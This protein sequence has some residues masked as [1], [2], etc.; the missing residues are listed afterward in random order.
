MSKNIEFVYFVYFQDIKLNLM[1]NRATRLRGRSTSDA[2]NDSY[3]S[4]GK[5]CSPEL[6]QYAARLCKLCKVDITDDEDQLYRRYIRL[7][8]VLWNSTSQVIH[9]NFTNNL[10]CVVFLYHYNIPVVILVQLPGNCLQLPG[11]CFVL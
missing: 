10:T 3:S 5:K 6:S 2:S 1:P 8:P 11:N 9:G 4:G 7:I